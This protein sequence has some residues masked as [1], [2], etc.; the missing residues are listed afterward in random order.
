M[1][2]HT[3]ISVIDRHDFAA[4]A[5]VKPGN[6]FQFL[7]VKFSHITLI[8]LITVQIWWRGFILFRQRRLPLYILFRRQRPPPARTL[9]LFRRR[10]HPLMDFHIFKLLLRRRLRRPLP[11]LSSYYYYSALNCFKLFRKYYRIMIDY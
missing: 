6:I 10:L 5:L 2:T 8:T 11:P 1:Q 7:S 4:K 3:K 9:I